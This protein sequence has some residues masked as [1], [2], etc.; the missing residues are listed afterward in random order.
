MRISRRLLHT[1]ALALYLLLTLGMTWPLLRVFGE[2]IPGDG[3]DGWQNYWNLWWMK[4]ALVDRVQSPYFTDLLFHPTGVGLLFHTLNP[5][6]GL[7]TLPVQLSGGLF[8]AYNSVVLLSWVLG[9]YGMFLLVRWLL[10]TAGETREPGSGG[11]APAD[12]G[13]GSPRGSRLRS[14]LHPLAL[15]PF[16]AGTIFTFAPFHMAHLLG[17]MQLMSLEWIPFYVLYLLRGLERVRGGR[18]WRREALLAGLFLTLVGLCD[19][20]YVLYLLIFTG[21]ALLVGMVRPSWLPGGGDPELS[22]PLGKRLRLL[23][24]PLVAGGLFAVVLSP[25]LVPMV[26]E[27]LRYRFMERPVSDLY[28]LSATLAD[29][30]IPNRL[31]PLFRPESFAWPGNQIAPV[32]ERT[33][34]IGYTAL[35]LAG[36][37]GLRR[38]A[39]SRFWL[40]TAGLFLLLALG[41]PFQ[42]FRLDWNDVPTADPGPSWTPYGILNRLVPFMRIS[43]S[44]SRMAIMVQFG[45][46]VAAAWGMVHWM[47]VRSRSGLWGILALA[48]VLFEFW[49]APF[50]VSP[51]DTP[52]F[53]TGLRE[54]PEPLAVL[55]LPMEFDRPGYLLYQTVHGK[56][57]TVAYISLD[58][59]RTY[60]ERIPVLQHFRH[61]GPDIL[62]VDPVAVASTVLQDLEVGWVVLDRYKMP[63]GQTREYTTRLAQAIF[64]GQ[65]PIYQDD[66]LTVYRVATSTAPRAYPVLGPEGWGPL[67]TDADPPYREIG[68]GPAAL[69]IRHAQGAWSVQLT[70][71][72]TPGDRFLVEVPGAPVPQAF[73]LDGSS[74]TV[75]VSLDPAPAGADGPRT[76]VLWTEQASLAVEAVRLIPME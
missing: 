39:R 9:G 2:A 49:V 32:S 62:D 5:F 72:G 26:R 42:L 12:V 45:V 76:L 57:L 17:H 41:P 25:V 27:A 68:P 58:D 14:L 64:A 8:P 43:R 55:N 56:P 20:Y 36:W 18:P 70:V 61:L 24:P 37:A 13:K 47:R 28:I 21:A 29:F 7:V 69:E 46:A 3:F 52:E 31:H 10:G 44:V 16:L 6:N 38:W 71:R 73:P 66:R 59:P 30:L 75:R 22:E 23:L 40:W 15:A 35:L 67:Q 51:P 33:I 74:Q 11:T 1:T 54:A 4:V 48:L 50:P 63:G 19:W 65:A 53:Y 34:A 60:T